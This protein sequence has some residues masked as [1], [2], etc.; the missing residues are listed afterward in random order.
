LED[1]KEKKEL[2]WDIS[3]EELV[4]TIAELEKK[5]ADKTIMPKERKVT[6]L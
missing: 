1:K 6:G 3:E 5:K 4:S 2:H